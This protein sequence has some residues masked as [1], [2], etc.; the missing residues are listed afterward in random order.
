MLLGAH[1]FS[2]DVMK[3]IFVST[4]TMAPWGGSEELW[5][6]TAL[7]L[8]EAG[9]SVTVCIA[10]WPKVHSGVQRMLQTGIEVHYHEQFYPGL[11][12]KAMNTICRSNT[13]SHVR[14]KIGLWL[15]AQQ[16]DL[17]CISM[18]N[19]FD[20]LEW[21]AACRECA[22]PYLTISQSNAEFLWPD[23]R[24]AKRVADAYQ[25]ARRC[26]FVSHRNQDLLQ[27]QLAL[28]LPNAC[29]VHN[30]FNVRY[31]NHIPWPEVTSEYR[32]ACV[33]RL[34]PG[35]KGQDLLLQVLALDKWRQRALRVSFYGSGQSD[36]SLQRLAVRL[37]LESVEFHGHVESVEAIWSRH[38]ALIL[39]SRIEGLPLA[40]VEAMLCHRL[41]IVT[42]VGGNS[43][44][45]IDG[46]NGFVAAAPTAPLLD[47][48]MERAW[49]R[50]DEWQTLGAKAR[51]HVT[52]IFSTD[53]IEQFSD[54]VRETCAPVGGMSPP[55][56]SRPPCVPGG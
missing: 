21:M 31:D 52:S 10:R 29:V 16:P 37:G 45:I 19:C 47:E 42:D 9:H 26:C 38:H 14:R 46:V 30:P 3:F 32:L 43:E 48:A 44:L 50:R 2:F 55:F 18:G 53:P 35:H 54:L 7:R 56:G 4:M 11:A 17:V 36:Q 28:E 8:K 15:T 27:N 5:S 13:E 22:L 23:D 20:G 39:P 51:Q 6:R 24:M 1:A 12:M 41:G 33:A 40:L 25:S 34:D 49:L